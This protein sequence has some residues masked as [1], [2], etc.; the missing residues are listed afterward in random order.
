MN[1]PPVAEILENFIK[2]HSKVYVD[3]IMEESEG[4]RRNR[5]KY[6]LYEAMEFAI[7]TNG[8]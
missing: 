7:Q 5:L 3:L 8:R 6:L 1:K 2:Q 4:K